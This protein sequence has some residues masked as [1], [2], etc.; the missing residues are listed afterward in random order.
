VLEDAGAQSVGAWATAISPGPPTESGQSVAFAVSTDNPS[1]FSTQPAV[2]ADGTLTYAPAADASGFA[3]V[4]V[5]AVDDGGTANGGVDTSAPA[6]FTVTVNPVNDAP[7]FVAGGNQLAVSLLG[8]QSVPGWATGISPGPANE[9]AQSVG[10]V[11]TVDNPA[12][13]AVQ[14]AVAADGTL[15]YTPNL[16]ALGVATVTVRAVDTGGTADGGTDTSA[17]QTFTITI[18]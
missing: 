17:P 10:F 14:P 7:T 3:T 2:A 13:F 15:T 4:T 16:L 18:L 9:S 1:L 5:S 12:L 6:M 8:A 11:V